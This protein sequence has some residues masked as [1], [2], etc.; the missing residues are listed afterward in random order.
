MS[1]FSYEW[2]KLMIYQRGL[3]YILA[4][5]LVSTVWLAATDRPQNSAMEEYREEY[6]WYLERLDGAYTEEKAA[7]L[8]QEAQAITEARYAR[9]GSQESYYS[10][11]ITAKQYER[12]I[13]EVNTVLAHEHGFEAAYRQY[14]YVCENTSN[15]YF[16]NTN[17]W[18]G[19]FSSQTLDFPL[20]LV[21]LILAATV[22]CS[23]YSCQMDA[24]LRTAPQSRKSARSKAV[25]TLCAVFALCGGLA[26]IRFVFFGMKYGLP[27]GEYP[28]Q[29]IASFGG[30]TKNV[31]LLAAYLILTALR[32]FGSVYLAALLLFT[33]VLVKKYALTVV[34]GVAST[35]IPY[36]GLSRQI[37]YRLP[38]PLPFLL[39]SG[40]LEG[41]SFVEDSLTGEPIVTFSERSPQELLVLLGLS[42]VCCALM[43]WWVLRQN[44]NYWQAGRKPV[45]GCGAAV[46]CL[47]V[48]LSLSGCSAKESTNGIF[49][50]SSQSVSETYSVIFDDQTRTYSL[51]NRATGALTDLAL[52][53][54]FGVFSDGESIKAVYMDAPY[55]YYM[56]SRTDQYVDRVGSY[57]STATQVSIVQFHTETFEEQVI[58]EKITDSGRSLLGIDYT[59]GDTWMFLQYCYG[60]FLNN[61]SFFFITNDGI[62]EVGRTSQR[63]QMLNIPTK[64]N[65]AF[66]GRTIYFI[67]EDSLLTAYDTRTHKARPFR[68][69]VAS[70]FRLTD[71]GLYFINR[72]DSECVYLCGRDGV[73]SLKISNDAARSIDYDG[74]KVT[75]FL[76]FA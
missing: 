32:C 7:W 29:S 44:T 26:L 53:P 42:A 30:S 8:E 35:L 49:N 33:S 41:A 9:S 24:L 31:S 68:N 16:L 50:S 52:S 11:Q 12:Q 27:H 66:D 3:C 69:M 70:D 18:A 19:L 72:M 39:T 36:I 15:R 62:T 14:L 22:F 67:N 2:K 73:D 17:G 10:G 60:F 56:T 54:L 65:I 4:A 45:K 40:F 55:I 58:F 25:M 76:Y 28:V 59:V 61:N 13:A 21:I 47:L 5:L 34:I 46:L 64:G 57:N 74:E 20:F 1:V 48:L 23:E 43:V 38:L 6:E 71:Q 63:T 37:C 75:I 51:E